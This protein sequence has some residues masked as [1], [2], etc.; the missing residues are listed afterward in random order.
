MPLII[1]TYEVPAG[2]IASAIYRNSNVQ[3]LSFESLRR[4]EIQ[5]DNKLYFVHKEIEFDLR[6]I[7][8]YF[9]EIIEVDT[10][11]MQINKLRKSVRYFRYTTEGNLKI[12]EIKKMHKEKS[13]DKTS[14]LPHLKAQEDEIVIFPEDD[15]E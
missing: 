1:D 13:F 2:E 12:E 11:I 15:E 3:P 7:K 10:F 14:F 6:K 4:G 5:D 8:Y 9:N